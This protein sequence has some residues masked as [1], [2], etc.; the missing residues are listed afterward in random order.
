MWWGHPRECRKAQVLEWFH[1]HTLKETLRDQ[2]GTSPG[3]PRNV[4]GNASEEPFFD[5]AGRVPVLSR[6]SQV[7]EPMHQAADGVDNA[8]RSRR[9][10]TALDI[11]WRK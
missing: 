10:T 4:T 2:L 3:G 8:P 9:E 1:L 11:G 6:A 5:E 7:A